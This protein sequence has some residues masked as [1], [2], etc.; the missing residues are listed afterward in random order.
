MKVFRTI[1]SILVVASIIMAGCTQT[2]QPSTEE[3]QTLVAQTVSALQT[4]LALQPTPTIETPTPM[5]IPTFTSIPTLIPT[6]TPIPPT[7][8]IAVAY[9]VASFSDI[10]VIT[11]PAP[12]MGRQTFIRTWKIV[13]GGTAAWSS[14]FKI[15]FVSGDSMGV[16]SITLGKVVYPGSY[17]E[18]SITFTAPVT[19][20]THTASFK[21]ATDKGNTFGLGTN[22]DRPWSMSIS[23]Q[24]LFAVTAASLTPSTTSYNGACP[25]TINLTP[26]ITANGSGIVTYYVHNSSGVLSTTYSMTFTSSG[27]QAGTVI[28]VPIDSSMASLQANLYVDNPNHQDISSINIPILCT[29]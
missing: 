24:N 16:N 18:V 3:L 21:L 27:T 25:A 28:S 6:D 22:S 8:T 15:I 11:T 12:Y 4:Q 20:G 17:Y 2:N 23:V 10:T 14:D 7:P 5:E 29:P 13:N 19:A 9:S 1:F 26:N